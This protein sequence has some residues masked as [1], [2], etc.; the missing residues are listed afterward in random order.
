MDMMKKTVLT[1]LAT[2]AIAAAAPAFAIEA[3]GVI[4]STD[5]GSN[6]ITM[7]DGSE[8]VLPEG[9][10]MAL[11]SVGMKVVLAY[12]AEGGRNIVTDMEKAE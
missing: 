4:A 12:D 2:L 1:L 6:T 5:A 3:Q 10:D 8:Y 9:F 11:V 7:D